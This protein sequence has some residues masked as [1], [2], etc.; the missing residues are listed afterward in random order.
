VLGVLKTKVML[1]NYISFNTNSSRSGSRLQLKFCHPRTVSATH[2][3]FYFSQMVRL[4]N[5]LPLTTYIYH[6]AYVIKQ[7]LTKHLWNH[8]TVHFNSHRPYH[9]CMFKTINHHQ[10]SP[11][12]ITDI[13][14]QTNNIII[15]VYRCTFLAVPTDL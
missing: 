4:W 14:L 5:H 3:H 1:A 10:L 13:N 12:L 9:Q 7:K 6:L 15:N 2:H 11:S 8:F